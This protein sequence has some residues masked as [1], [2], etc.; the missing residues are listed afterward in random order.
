MVLFK[1]L[2]LKI[3]NT[4]IELSSFPAANKFPSMWLTNVVSGVLTVKVHWKS[5]NDQI[6]SSMPENETI[7]FEEKGKIVITG[8]L[9]KILWIRL[10]LS[11]DQILI[12]QSFEQVIKVLLCSMIVLTDWVCALIETLNLRRFVSHMMTVPSAEAVAKVPFDKFAM[13]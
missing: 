6:L 3:S 10:K 13:L 11:F 1:L 9:S 8:W 4:K 5:F 7:R 2:L 12:E